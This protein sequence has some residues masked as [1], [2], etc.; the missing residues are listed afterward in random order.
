MK[1][2]IYLQAGAVA[3]NVVILYRRMSL[4]RIIEVGKDRT[5]QFVIQGLEKFSLDFVAEKIMLNQTWI[6]GVV[7]LTTRY[8]TF[9]I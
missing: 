5:P 9:G 3:F 6:C 8:F 2:P 7:Q 4:S 1:S